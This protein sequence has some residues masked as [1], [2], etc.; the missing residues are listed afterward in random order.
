M[1]E[2]AQL[3]SIYFVFNRIWRRHATARNSNVGLSNSLLSFLN[4]S[5]VGPTVVVAVAQQGPMV[6]GAAPPARTK[7]K[8]YYDSIESESNV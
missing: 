5:G 3:S 2:Y 7:G 6:P 4:D 1:S 8:E